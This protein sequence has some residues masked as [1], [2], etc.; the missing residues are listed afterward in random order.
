VPVSRQDTVSLL[1]HVDGKP[2]RTEVTT[3][4]DDLTTEHSP[5]ETDL[6]ARSHFSSPA[7]HDRDGATEG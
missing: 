1:G 4:G 7:P 3:V 5:G 2:F 6:I